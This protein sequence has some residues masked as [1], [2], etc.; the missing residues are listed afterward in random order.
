MASTYI[1]K[2]FSVPY[3]SAQ[4]M[5]TVFNP[6]GSGK[7]VRVYRAWVENNG[8]TAVT[9][10]SPILKL[11]RATAASGGVTVTPISYDSTNTALGTVACGSKQT[12]TASSL[13][14]NRVVSNDEA[15]PNT[16]T[17]DEWMQFIPHMEL[18][19]VGTR[20]TNLDPIVCRENQGF[21]I[22]NSTA[23]TVSGIDVFIEFTVT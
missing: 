23:T 19:N 20:N 5:L 7:I 15:V 12:V 17:V 3:A 4:Y 13:F 21:T 16:G 11:Y 2:S 8:F 14:G 1:V 9:G 6:T 18:L 22:Q 10:V